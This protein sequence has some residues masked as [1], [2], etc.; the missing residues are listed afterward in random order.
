[1][2]APATAGRG[3]VSFRREKFIEFGGPDGGDGG[4]GGDVVVE[5]VSG[6]NTLIDFRYQQHFKGKTG[7]HGMGKNRAGSQG[8]RRRAQGA[9]RHAAPRRGRRGAVRRP[10]R[11]RP[12]RAR[13]PRRQRRVRQCL[14]QNQHQ[15]GAAPCQPRRDRRG[16]HAHP[17]PEADRRCRSR[18]PTQRRKVDLPLRGVGGQAEDRRLSLHHA[19]PRSS[20]W[21]AWMGASSCWP[22]FR[23]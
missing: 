2:S 22:T 21:W 18:R 17:A 10:D 7:T 13:L 15:P 23:G 3:C 16:A 9:C 8:S 1:M 11:D 19:A 5:C 6:L 12:E 4:K 14:F 20:A